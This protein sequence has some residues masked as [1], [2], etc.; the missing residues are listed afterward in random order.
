[1]FFSSHLLLLC[2]RFS[3]SERP[4]RV[5]SSSVDLSVSVCLSAGGQHPW[6]TA[7]PGRVLDGAWR[8]VSSGRSLSSKL[9]LIEP[10]FLLAHAR[11]PTRTHARVGGPHPHSSRG[12][13]SVDMVPGQ[14]VTSESLKQEGHE[15]GCVGRRSRGL[16]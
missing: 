7:W 3:S 14:F 10:R 4:A 6:A 8:T 13:G 2:S 16:G 1:M 11:V 9:G 12:L 15:M 5:G